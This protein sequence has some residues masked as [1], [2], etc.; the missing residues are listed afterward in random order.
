MT[1]VEMLVV[2][3]IIAVTASVSVLAL[4]GDSNLRGQAEAK[5]IAARLQL[6]ADQTM[7]DG[8]PRAMVVTAD[9]YRFVQFDMDAGEWVPIADRALAEPFELPGDMGLRGAEGQSLYPL[10]ADG[11]GAPFTL[12]LTWDDRQWVVA[13]N[14]VTA[15]VEQISVSEDVKIGAFQAPGPRLGEAIAA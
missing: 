13:F 7:I 6:A 1:L 14:G 11:S 2:L 15:S 4:G 3:A 9:D 5:R 8:L 10:G 12:N